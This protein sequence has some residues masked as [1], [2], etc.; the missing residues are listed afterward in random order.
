M[1]INNDSLASLASS[2]LEPKYLPVDGSDAAGGTSLGR[3]TG[4][5]QPS[6]T[7]SAVPGTGVG[8]FVDAAPQPCMFTGGGCLSTG[9]YE[10]KNV[11]APQFGQA[12]TG[13]GFR[14]VL[15]V[16]GMQGSHLDS[17]GSVW[18]RGTDW[19][20]TSAQPDGGMSKHQYIDLEEDEEEAA[21]GR[22][23][24]PYPE[25]APYYPAPDG[26]GA[27][28][29]AP[30]AYPVWGGGLSAPPP[31]P[32]AMQCW[33][34]NPTVNGLINTD[35][36]VSNAGA[37]V[38][39]SIGSRGHPYTCGLACKYASRGRGCKD[40]KN[41]DRCHLCTWRRNANKMDREQATKHRSRR[42]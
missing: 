13:P 32:S 10:V 22:F 4:I 34:C 16:H 15:P 20:N 39:F 14:K 18:P 1:Y 30:L 28:G 23:E 25:A 40:G 24:V 21:L 6:S 33:E 19:E 35:F 42:H 38:E 29:A 12:L 37:D 27:L 11:H 36:S 9:L 5:P 3:K 2:N 8:R 26:F 31:A 17:Q 41:C 7:T